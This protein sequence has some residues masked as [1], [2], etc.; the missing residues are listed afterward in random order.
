MPPVCIHRC[1]SKIR[2]KG[3]SGT[4]GH[5]PDHALHHLPS[6]WIRACSRKWHPLTPTTRHITVLSMWNFKL[7]QKNGLQIMFSVCGCKGNWKLTLMYV[8]GYGCISVLLYLFLHTLI[9]LC[10][11]LQPPLPSLYPCHPRKGLGG[12]GGVGGG[13]TDWLAEVCFTAVIFLYWM[14]QRGQ[15]SRL[16]QKLLNQEILLT[17]G[18]EGVASAQ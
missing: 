18:R 16:F 5:I 17:L 4:C 7:E 10:S 12:V 2:F 8:H 13:H 9:T 1:E 6:G 11:K 3:S 14:L 15:S